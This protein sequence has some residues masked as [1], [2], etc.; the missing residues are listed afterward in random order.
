MTHSDFDLFT[1]EHKIAVFH[2]DRT[3]DLAEPNKDEETKG[4]GADKVDI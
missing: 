1:T 2:G 3:I 4:E